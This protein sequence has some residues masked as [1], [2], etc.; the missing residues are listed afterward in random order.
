MSESLEDEFKRRMLFLINRDGT[1][2]YIPSQ[3]LTIG[4]LVM[5][6]GANSF[7]N[8]RWGNMGIYYTLSAYDEE[9]WVYHRHYVNN[10]IRQSE[11]NLEK[12]KHYMPILQRLMP[13]EDLADV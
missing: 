4:D 2:T 13:L 6:V 12:I 9:D 1:A 8:P 10:D 7:G 3:E 11:T 5:S